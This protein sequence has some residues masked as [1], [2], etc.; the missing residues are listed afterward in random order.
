MKNKAKTIMACGLFSCLCGVTS[1]AQDYYGGSGGSWRRQPANNNQQ[2]QQT[3]DSNPEPSG[4]FS[5]NFGFATPEGSFAATPV[6][7][8]NDNGYGNY[9]QP[10]SMFHFSLGIPINHSNF[11]VAFM[12]GSYDNGYDIN[13][14]ANNNGVYALPPNTG[15]SDYTESSIMGGF[16]AT[17]PIGKLS[18]D[19][20][21][22]LGAL[23]NGLPEQ[24]FY[25]DDNMN[26]QWQID[27]QPSYPTSLA[28]DAGVGARYMIAEFG[29][30]KICV[31]VNIDYMYSNV[32]YNTQPD[33]YETYG[34]SAGANAGTTVQYGT[35]SISGKIPIQLFNV[36]F[37]IGYQL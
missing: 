11:G 4:Y 12:F 3:Q 6:Y 22:M 29:R 28:F 37:G 26:N 33:V 17:Y 9:A 27:V 10:G 5:I 19:G 18:I 35:S 32:S 13:T 16:Y 15:Q 36:T 8:G 24:N 7:T 34:S 1:N 21:L 14:F 23:L 31:M 30:R 2:Q 20:R 25:Y